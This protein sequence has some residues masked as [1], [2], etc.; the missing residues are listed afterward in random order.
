[1][2]S[3]ITWHKSSY[4]N[5]GTNCVE[6]AEGPTTHICDTQNRALAQLN[7]PGFEWT[8]LL[9]TLRTN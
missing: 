7:V 2:T 9:S 4:S 1:M 6:V 3:E 8:A 5:G